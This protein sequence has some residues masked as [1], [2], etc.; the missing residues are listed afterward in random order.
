MLAALSPF[1]PP[2]YSPTGLFY[3]V[4]QTWRRPPSIPSPTA[5]STSPPL[6]RSTACPPKGSPRPSPPSPRA[7][8]VAPVIYRFWCL[9]LHR[10]VPGNSAVAEV[11]RGMAIYRRQRF[12]SGEKD[13]PRSLGWGSIMLR[14]SEYVERCFN[15]SLIY[16]REGHGGIRY[17]QLKINARLFQWSQ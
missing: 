14:S 8:S 9:S 7:F 13:V 17:G 2:L 15:R 6:A 1:F 12:A 4:A 16:T 3:T 5:E 10:G 11:G